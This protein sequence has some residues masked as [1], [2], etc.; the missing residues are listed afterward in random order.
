MRY[1][2]NPQTNEKGHFVF[3]GCD[4]VELAERFG[5]PLY[6]MDENIIRD[7]C[8]A[9]LKSFNE[10][11]IDGKV[12][13]ASKAF[14]C[15]AIYRILTQ[16][17]LG[18]DVVSGGELYTALAAGMPASDIYFHGNNKTEAEIRMALENKI[19]HIVIDNMEEIFR[20]IRICK[21][22]NVTAPVSIRLKPGI[23]AHT[24]EA[25]LTGANDSKFGLGI[26]DG[27]ALKAV[28]TILAEPCLQLL[29][30]HSHIGSQIF[31]VSAFVQAALILTNFIVEVQEK[32][33]YSIKEINYGGGYGIS[34]TE[35]DDP[36]NPWEYVTAIAKATMEECDKKGLKD[37]KLAIEPGRALVG[38]A[39]I[40]LYTVGSV[41]RIPEGRCYVA[42]DGGMTDN[43]RYALYESRYS[44]LIANK[45]NAQK[46]DFITLAGRCC[47][48]GDIIIRDTAFAKAQEGDIV[49]VFA[50][51]AYNY[52]M[53]SHYN[54]VPNAAVVLVN[55]GEADIIVKRESYE[56]LAQNDLI[57]DRLK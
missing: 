6:V 4:T 43:P 7:T 25:V 19:G 41:K 47:E 12:L 5:T 37:I 51:G 42:V 56:Q 54:R 57:P 11:G 26:Q 29:G 15:K 28:E 27:Q 22:M 48:S 45:P 18:V 21:E 33:D 32:F 16:E 53:A 52:A 34:Y 38:E 50:T 31:D 17:G 36:L 39:G 14:S 24:H 1:W 44:A 55:N 3:G 30:I 9:F 49:A 8:R 23:D 40:T 13:F 20:I 35:E 46:D 2:E 10:L